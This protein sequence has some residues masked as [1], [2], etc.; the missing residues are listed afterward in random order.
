MVGPTKHR[1]DLILEGRSMCLLSR[2]LEISFIIYF[3][4]FHI[5]TIIYT[6]GVSMVL[7][8]CAIEVSGDQ[9]SMTIMIHFH[10]LFLSYSTI[11]LACTKV[12]TPKYIFT[13]LYQVLYVQLI[14]YQKCFTYPSRAL[15]G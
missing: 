2:G 1:E 12:F 4:Y 13:G 8:F 14:N 10:T 5:M 11:I 6:N 9:P 7:V 15:S 3:N